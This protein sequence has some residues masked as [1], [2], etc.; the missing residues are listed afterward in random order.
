M[1]F[2]LNALFSLSI[3]IG[4]IIGWIRYH[5]IDSAYLPFVWLL[6]LAF[7]CEIAS[8]ILIESGYSN[9]LLYNFFAL[10]EALILVHLFK[11]WFL[12]RPGS[13]TCLILQVVFISVFLVESIFIRHWYGFNSYFIIGFSATIVVLSINMLNRIMF[14]VPGPL[15]QHSIFLICMGLIIYF[16]YAILIEAFWLYGLNQS[17]AFRIRIY[18]ILSYINL[19]TNLAF[20]LATIWMPLKRNYILRY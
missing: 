13:K 16:T 18:Q 9:S 3:G 10:G 11:K 6:W 5:R 12:F 8:M 7:I 19:I 20:A 1:N 2:I 4:A 15:L 17:T 14:E